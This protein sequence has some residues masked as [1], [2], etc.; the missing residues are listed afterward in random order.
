[1]I[2]KIYVF[3]FVKALKR[4]ERNKTNAI[5]P[6][7]RNDNDRWCK[8]TLW[9]QVID[10][11]FS[12]FTQPNLKIMIMLD[13]Y[14]P[15]RANKTDIRFCSL[16]PFHLFLAFYFSSPASR[17]IRRRV[18]CAGHLMTPRRLWLNKIPTQ[19]DVVIEF[20]GKYNYEPKHSTSAALVV[21]PVGNGWILFLTF[22]TEDAPDD[23]LRWLLNRIKANPPEGL[24]LSAMVR[25]H[26]S[27]KR[28]A[29]YITAPMNV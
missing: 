2:S 24:G 25:A 3:V 28:T 27:T 7:N 17:L 1:M 21:L 15:G 22:T 5:R 16:L 26:E 14:R 11:N 6:G 9:Y 4:I 20:P 18:P 29:F 10:T 19:C 12:I 23:A 13:T 8:S